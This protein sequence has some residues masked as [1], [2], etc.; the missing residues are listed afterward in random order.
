M[1]DWGKLSSV[2]AELSFIGSDVSGISEFFRAPESPPD[3]L[4]HET[5]KVALHDV[6]PAASELSLEREGFIVADFDD[7][8]P[9]YNDR[10]QL[11][12][13][14]LPHVAELLK[15]ETGADHVF[16]WAFGRRFS[17]KLPQSRETQ[18]STAAVMVH[19]DFSPGP[20]GLTIDNKTVDQV[21]A[22]IVGDERPR[23]WKAMNVWQPTTPPPHDR[24]VAL[25]DMSSLHPEDVCIA[26]G[27]STYE[28]GLT[29]KHE[30]TWAKYGAHQRWAYFRNLQPGQAIIFNGLDMEDGPIFGLVEHA[31]FAL[32]DLPADALP[33]ESVETRNI[34]IWD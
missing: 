31:A 13:I 28:N 4:P 23:R 10:S 14:W 3:H 20:I 12:T 26:Q 9:D 6:S 16:S 7:G 17:P 29:V 8:Q 11:E 27:S 30:L 18:V 19:T 33:R 24:P 22:G 5:H 2:E 32:P 25:C 21:I 15:R 34:V 1:L